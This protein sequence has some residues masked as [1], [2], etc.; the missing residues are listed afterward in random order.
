M[1]SSGP[2]SG[3]DAHVT[4]GS[5]PHHNKPPH[6]NNSNNANNTSSGGANPNAKDRRRERQ[7]QGLQAPEAV[8][9]AVPRTLNVPE[10]T[11]ARLTEMGDFARSMQEGTSMRRVYQTVPRHMR[12]RAMSHNA[13]RLPKK[14][15]G[16]ALR[17]MAKMSKPNNG[18]NP[19][20]A[21]SSASNDAMQSKYSEYL[22]PRATPAS[23]RAR[24][25]P[26]TLLRD[27]LRRS[28]RHTWL[29][30]HLWHARR[31]HMGSLWG[32]RIAVKAMDKGTRAMVR[33]AQAQAV[34]HDMSY[35]TCLEIAVSGAE[36]SSSLSSASASTNS[37]S[38]SSIVIGRA[39]V[40]AVLN[41]LVDSTRADAAAAALT[42]FST[43]NKAYVSCAELAADLAHASGTITADDYLAVIAAL[44]NNTAAKSSD[45]HQTATLAFGASFDSA[46][47]V[48]PRAVSQTALLALRSR[49]NDNYGTSSDTTSS[50]HVFYSQAPLPRPVDDAEPVCVPAAVQR[51]VAAAVS[52]SVSSA[53]CA[54]GDREGELVLRYPAL[55]RMAAA[56][57]VLQAVEAFDGAGA[58]AGAGFPLSSLLPLELAGQ[59]IGPVSFMW[60]PTATAESAAAADR[61]LAS[62]CGRLW[63]WVHPAC[64][65]QVAA[66]L[67]ALAAAHTAVHTA[68]A[69]ATASRATSVGGAVTVKSLAGELARIRV[70]G[71][72]ALSV[73][74]N[75]LRAHPRTGADADADNGDGAHSHS[76]QAR[77]A[78]AW[79]SLA[80]H[81]SA[82]PFVPHGAVLALTVTHPSALLT[83]QRF[84]APPRPTAPLAFAEAAAVAAAAAP[85]P[86]APCPRARQGPRLRPRW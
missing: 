49:V 13:H 74:Q 68:T 12:R 7:Q 64:A 24:R 81:R 19:G 11:A 17:E 72:R 41:S 45:N 71:P 78:A 31:M 56:K 22:V 8:R 35:L 63:L 27:H 15:R 18:A 38:S 67:S 60:Q 25:A 23:R 1:S 5:R 84:T 54:R 14:L 39:A 28:T 75:V 36:H 40:E 82:A 79:R 65:A 85:P 66:V 30:T 9:A 48:S 70:C 52:H 32:H 16:P 57:A 42:Q 55:P 77:A 58:G 43:A 53:A 46:G 80:G 76:S 47:A 6:N 10:Y 59:P 69:T 44:D 26:A 50:S 3:S 86:P 21:A 61:G 34:S 33:A 83:R 2:G 29:E 20:N 51:A 62:D 37:S 73:M 4:G